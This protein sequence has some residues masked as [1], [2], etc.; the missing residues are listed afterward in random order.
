MHDM[1]PSSLALPEFIAP[2]PTHWSASASPKP[3]PSS[4][5]KETVEKANLNN[6]DR[7]SFRPKVFA[8]CRISARSCQVSISLVSCRVH[9]GNPIFVSIEQ[10]IMRRLSSGETYGSN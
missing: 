1:L 9:Y 4:Y 2:T 7:T 5:L 10:N 6:L 3:N 8:S